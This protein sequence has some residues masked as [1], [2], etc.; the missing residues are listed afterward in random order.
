MTIEQ[1]QTEMKPEK[2][3]SR[4]RLYV[5]LDRFK[6]KPVSRVR[7]TPQQYP[8]DTP[9]KILAKLG[10]LKTRNGKGRR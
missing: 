6:I 9:Q 4:A 8:E 3:V 10:L 2:P 1:I 5:Y 7:Q